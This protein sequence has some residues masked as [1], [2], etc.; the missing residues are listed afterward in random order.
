MFYT[1]RTEKEHHH[2][3]DLNWRDQ[4]FLFKKI[5][6]IDQVYFYLLSVENMNEKSFK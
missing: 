3:S 5:K 1:A 6:F 2:H 4:Q